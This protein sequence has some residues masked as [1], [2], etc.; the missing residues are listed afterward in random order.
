MTRIIVR[1]DSIKPDLASLPRKE[2]CSL[3]YDIAD[4]VVADKVNIPGKPDHTVLDY[5]T[6][7]TIADLYHLDREAL[8]L[9]NPQLRFQPV[10]TPPNRPISTEPAVRFQQIQ[11]PCSVKMTVGG[12]YYWPEP[13]PDHPDAV[14]P[15]TVER[16]VNHDDVDIYFGSFENN[17]DGVAETFYCETNADDETLSGTP[18]VFKNPIR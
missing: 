10:A 3:I 17:P 4:A 15:F 2:D 18:E 13:T 6:L 11:G 9:Q 8:C 1:P 14:H 5:E 12:S 7:A 16:I